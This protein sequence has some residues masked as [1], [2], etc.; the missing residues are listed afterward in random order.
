MFNTIEEII[1]SC[2]STGEACWNDYYIE[3]ERGKAVLYKYAHPDSMSY[4]HCIKSGSL[5]EL[6][7]DLLR[8]EDGLDTVWGWF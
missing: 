4:N 2:I 7:W 8:Y 3:Y 5:E 6:A 1:E